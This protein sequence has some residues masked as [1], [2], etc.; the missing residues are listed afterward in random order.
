[1]LIA[2][3]TALAGQRFLSVTTWNVAAINNNVRSNYVVIPWENN[4]FRDPNQTS[5]FYPPA[6]D[7]P[8]NIGLHTMKTQRT[9]KL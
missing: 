7:S 5:F 1:M 3:A 2:K 6:P 4:P 8:L 9:K